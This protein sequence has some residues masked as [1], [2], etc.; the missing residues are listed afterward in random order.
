[1]VPQQSVEACDGVFSSATE[2]E[3]HGQNVCLYFKS[4]GHWKLIKCGSMQR[5]CSSA[6]GGSC[7]VKDR[8][9]LLARGP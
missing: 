4:G 9:G 6:V 5:L 3:V 2:A 1:M 7:L 8:A